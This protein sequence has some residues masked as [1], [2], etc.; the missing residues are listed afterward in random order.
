VFTFSN[1]PVGSRCVKHQAIE[2]D[3]PFRARN[4]ARPSPPDIALADRAIM[5][6]LGISSEE[7]A[8]LSR[9][10]LPTPYDIPVPP[11]KSG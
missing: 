3:V 10:I 5:K 1:Y 7:S 6:S 2:R 4:E 8:Y 9:V 11:D